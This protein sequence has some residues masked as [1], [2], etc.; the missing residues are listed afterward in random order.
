MNAD[1]GR[2]AR[3]HRALLLAAGF[4]PGLAWPLEPLA[5]LAAPFQDPLQAATALARAYQSRGAEAL[6]EQRHAD[7]K[8]TEHQILME[9]VKAHADASATLEDL[10][11][12]ET[13]LAAGQESQAVSAR[14]RLLAKPG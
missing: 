10:R 12:S 3:H 6:V 5:R 11:A 9:M 2:G 7:L 13:L 8:D 4:L 14:L 1:G